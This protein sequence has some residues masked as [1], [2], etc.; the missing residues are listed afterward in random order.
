MS[1]ESNRWVIKE[2]CAER[3]ARVGT[4]SQNGYG[5]QDTSQKLCGK[6][7]CILPPED[8]TFF[9]RIPGTTQ[10]QL[11]NKPTWICGQ[12][13]PQ[14]LETPAHDKY[15]CVRVSICACH[16]CAGTVLIFFDFDG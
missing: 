2:G 9:Q 1:W 4:L 12:S 10:N 7:K 6:Q 14:H 3:I 16:P 5:A 15:H 13:D 11:F 8:R